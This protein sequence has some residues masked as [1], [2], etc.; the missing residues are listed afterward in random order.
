M[1]CCTNFLDFC[2]RTGIAELFT[3]HTDAAFLSARM[4][5]DA[6]STPSRWLPAPLHL[7]GPLLSLNYL[8]LGDKLAIARA[9]LRLFATA[10]IRPTLPDGPTVLSWLHEQRQAPAAIERFWK[11]VLVSA[12]AESLDRAS[13]AAARK[14]FVDGFLAHP[15]ACRCAGA[16]SVAR[17]AL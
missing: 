16:A 5:G 15:D 11:V 14:V 4:A 2:Q 6:T 8:S 13:L 17:R 7:V 10:A 1:G 3:R 9:M 12:L